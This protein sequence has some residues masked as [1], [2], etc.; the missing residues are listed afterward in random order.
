MA[1][2]LPNIPNLLFTTSRAIGEGI[3][4]NNQQQ[5]INSQVKTYRLPACAFS[6]LDERTE[7]IT[8]TE[9]Y[10]TD[11][12]NTGFSILAPVQLP[13]GANIIAVV[14]FGNAGATGET[15]TLTQWSNDNTPGETIATANVGT[16]DTTVN[17]IVDNNNW[18]YILEVQALDNNDLIFGARILYTTEI[19]SE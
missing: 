13:Q 5:I 2:K 16:E 3:N 9:G 10:L 12:N 14:V 11:S 15:Y 1:L 4:T 7:P 18:S 19:E 6:S 8:Y 17:H